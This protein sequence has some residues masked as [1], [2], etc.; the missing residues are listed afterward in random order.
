M[1]ALG[2]SDGVTQFNVA[3]NSVSSSLKSPSSELESEG[4]EFNSG[5]V[6][7]VE[8]RKLDT[9]FS[10][11]KGASSKIFL[12]LDVQGAELEVLQGALESLPS[13]DGVLSEMNTMQL[14]QG[15]S[16]CSDVDDF[17]R[18]K[19]FELWDIQTGFR[20]KSSGRLLQYDAVYFSIEN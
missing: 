3:D 20:S 13:V 5:K 15:I 2:S 12:K 14:Y 17:M 1:F 8:V 18:K 16:T 10:D 11:H 6:I 9:V 19:G 7:E 4:I